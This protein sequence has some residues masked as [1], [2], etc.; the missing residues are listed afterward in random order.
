[1]AEPP[2]WETG[3]RDGERERE[4]EGSIP[5]MIESSDVPQRSGSKVP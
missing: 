1:M 5:M 2:G 4:R 3:D